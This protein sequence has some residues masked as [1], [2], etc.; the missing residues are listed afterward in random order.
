MTRTT[1]W[2]LALTAALASAGL[3]FTVPAL[4]QENGFSPR[5]MMNGGMAAMH[6]S[7]MPLMSEMP[8]MHTEMLGDVAAFLGMSVDEL[9]GALA[10]GRSL[11]ELAVEKGRSFEE[12]QALMTDSMKAFVQRAVEAGSITQAQADQMLQ[13]HEQYSGSCH[14]VQS[15]GMMGGMMGG[16]RNMMFAP[17]PKY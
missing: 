6:N 16:M 7:M 17:N 15:G 10:E 3:I 14:A 8:T 2:S 13:Y 5:A 1:K 9:N 12:A 11:T 4:A